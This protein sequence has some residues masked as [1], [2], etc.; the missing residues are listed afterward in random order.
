MDHKNHLQI[1]HIDHLQIDHID[2][3]Q[4]DN[5][6]HLHVYIPGIYHLQIYHI[7][8]LYKHIIPAID[9]LQIDQVNHTYQVYHIDHLHTNQTDHLDHPVVSHSSPAVMR[10][11]AGS[12]CTAQIQP[13]KRRAT[14]VDHAHCH[15][16][17]PATRARSYRS[18]KIGTRYICLR[19]SR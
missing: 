15:S 18:Y 19:R 8:H 11:C 16:S 5:I 9:Y 13:R 14:A 10:G 2:H 12:I 7:N 1:D 6:D 17:H 4:I 3:L